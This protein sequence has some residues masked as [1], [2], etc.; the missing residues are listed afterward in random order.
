[1]IQQYDSLRQQFIAEL[2]VILS[3][4]QL[5]VDVAKAA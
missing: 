1:M 2:K 5:T 3:D 4:F